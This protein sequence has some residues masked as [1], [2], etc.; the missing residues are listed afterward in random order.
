MYISSQNL[1]RY[2]VCHFIVHI[3]LV[4]FKGT[5]WE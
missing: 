3:K 1:K 4:A 2:I 5:A